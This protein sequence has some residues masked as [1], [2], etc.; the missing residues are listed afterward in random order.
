MS[1]LGL[2]AASAAAAGLLLGATMA[3]SAGQEEPAYLG[4][5]PRGAATLAGLEAC[6]RAEPR[7]A[8]AVVIDESGSLEDTDPDDLRADAI[9]QFVRR[10]SDLTVGPEGADREF[11]LHV[12]FFAA[13]NTVWRDWALVPP[14]AAALY[15]DLR[16]SIE[17]RDR[18]SNTYFT[19]AI[20]PARRAVADAEVLLGARD[21]CTFTLW[22]SDGYPSD[23]REVRSLCEADGV[24]DRYRASGAPLIGILLDATA[25]TA[26][27]DGPLMREMVEGDG[28]GGPCGTADARGAHLEGGVDALIQMVERIISGQPSASVPGDPFVVQADPGV[29]RVRIVGPASAGIRIESPSGRVLEAAPGAPIAG[30]GADGSEARWFGGSV[31]VDLAIGGDHGPWVVRRGGVGGPMDLYHFSDLS[32][33][34]DA[35]ATALLRDVPS[36]V[37]GRILGPDGGPADLGAFAGSSLLLE[38]AD[39][40][41]AV[42]VVGADGAFRTELV[43]DAAVAEVELTLTLDLETVGGTA[44]QPVVGRE[45]VPVRLPQTFPLLEPAGDRFLPLLARAGDVATREVRLVGSPLG[46]TRVCAVVPDATAVAVAVP[47]LGDDGCID[48][49]ADERRTLVVEA[50]LVEPSLRGGELDVPVRFELRSATGAGLT[51]RTTD[52]VLGGGVPVTP[53]PPDRTA[54]W[55]LL[56]AGL[57]GPA[58]LLWL[59]NDRRATL[60]APVGLR[61]AHVRAELVPGPTEGAPPTLRRVEGAGGGPGTELLAPGDFGYPDAAT[62]PGGRRAWRVAGG[63]VGAGPGPRG[64]T[65]EVP[66]P[67]TP[68]SRPSPVVRAPAG[69][70]IVTSVG[71]RGG[72][73]DLRTAPA[74][75]VLQRVAHVVVSD[76]DLRRDPR[77]PV[78]VHLTVLIA[79]AGPTLAQEAASLGRRLEELLDGELLAA[80]RDAAADAAPSRGRSASP[81]GP[82]PGG[83]VPDGGARPSG[84]AVDDLFDFGGPASG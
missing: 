66:R 44:V 15:E 47:G 69:S 60:R 57:V 81:A 6:L 82:G 34:V 74:R 65:I 23:D 13:G 17:A 9:V 2:R 77:E 28:P 27:A 30:D 22:F 70:R 40:P 72:S 32:L 84:S 18:G 43:I 75:Q 63:Q 16:V 31:S 42:V 61:L 58:L 33:E 79:A 67:R 20:E 7:V 80:L 68:I 51:P 78:P 37:V 36:P 21:L 56:V 1:R 39:G 12:S 53:V 55:T 54:Y 71:G 59:L 73:Q 8:V 45:R 26:V 49:G 41:G 35:A 14:D 64:E 10:L 24:L 46:P 38:V 11:W 76:A 50:T 83:D 48:L 29:D 19:Q 62:P 52:L 25:G 5:S 4:L 3:P